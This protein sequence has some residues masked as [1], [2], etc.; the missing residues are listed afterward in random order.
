MSIT[1]SPAVCAE[2]ARP[3]PAGLPSLMCPQCLLGGALEEAEFPGDSPVMGDWRLLEEIGRGG[4]GVVYRAQ[5]ADGGPE[6][7]LKTLVFGELATPEMLRRFR[8]EAKA[9]AALQHPHLVP[10]LEVGDQEGVPFLVMTLIRGRTLGARLEEGAM[11]AREAAV[12][13]RTVAEAVSLMHRGGVLH[14]DLKPANILLDEDGQPFVSDFGLAKQLAGTSLTEVT[15]TGQV[16]GSPAYMAPEQARGDH[17]QT[18]PAS[19]VYALGAILYHLLTGRVPF[20]GHSTHEVLSQVEFDEPLPPRRVLAAVPRELETICLQCMEKEPSARCPSAAALA[21]DLTRWLEGTP[22]LARRAGFLRRRWRWCRRRPVIA[23]LAGVSVVLMAALGGHVLLSR[24][25]EAAGEQ[26]RLAGA[27]SAALEEARAAIASHE[28]ARRSRGLDAVKR[29]ASPE[30]TGELQDAVIALLTDYSFEPVVTRPLPSGSVAVTFSADLQ[31]LACV[32]QGRVRILRTSDGAEVLEFDESAARQPEDGGPEMLEFSPEGG[33]FA[34]HS[35]R[36]LVRLWRFTNF[37]ADQPDPAPA[38]AI[39]PGVEL[40]GKW[41]TTASATHGFMPVC[42]RGDRA[43]GLRLAPCAEHP[44]GAIVFMALDD[45]RER[46][47]LD[48]PAPEDFF[49]ANPVR[50]NGVL[51][52]DGALE[53]MHLTSLERV[54]VIKPPARVTCCVWQPDGSRLLAGCANGAVLCASEATRFG[55][56]LHVLYHSAPLNHLAFSGD[57]LM[58]LTVS[59]DTF[60]RISNGGGTNEVMLE[61]PG[62]TGHRFNRNGWYLSA[63]DA[64]GIM[65]LWRKT[66]PVGVVAMKGLVSGKFESWDIDFSTGTHTLLMDSGEN[67]HLK[68]IFNELLG[69]ARPAGRRRGAGFT[70]DGGGVVT[71]EAH[72]LVTRNTLSLAF[73]G[74]PKPLELGTPVDGDPAWLPQRFC[75]GSDGTI[76]LESA[77]FRYGVAR[78]PDMKSVRELSGRRASAQPGSGGGPGGSGTMAVSPDG[79]RVAGGFPESGAA[80]IWNART[81]GIEKELPDTGAVHFSP[82]GAWFLLG[83]EKLWRL[84]EVAS[85]RE[86]WTRPRQGSARQLGTAA[87]AADGRTVLLDSSSF[88]LTLVDTASARV[89]VNL[90]LPEAAACTS[91][92]YDSVASRLYAGTRSNNVWRWDLNILRRGI[93]AVDLEPGF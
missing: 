49:L 3:L 76:A 59:D 44:A 58:L 86:V 25:R 91:V 56:P 38:A 52:H 10:I 18:G 93:E 2:C 64:A 21:D 27:R 1:T 7:A 51:Y 90:P 8:Q 75:F 6:V 92:R 55:T 34:V 42:M 30:T 26:S 70:P 63:V 48:S 83:S 31:H 65:H 22:V 19:D 33:F 28:P 17:A 35:A 40:F 24:H 4:M 15:R 14:R 5:H 41:Q 69:Q 50:P 16:L 79:T 67:L 37:T 32:H 11:P 43:L 62:I 68:N 81:G 39:T 47:M 53:I 87:F 20:A 78:W 60:T 89:I 29:A 57:T 72:G 54:G 13:M 9:A 46:V 36:G 73:L 80:V 71:I 74:G 85:W 82:D 12:L 88:R 66:S 45:R 84:Y 23:A 77:D 61:M